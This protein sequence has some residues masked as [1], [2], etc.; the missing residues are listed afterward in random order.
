MAMLEPQH[1]DSYFAWNF[2][3]GILMQ[4][5]HFSSYVFEDLAA[6]MLKKDIGL[7][8]AFESKKRSDTTFAEDASA[9]LNWIYQ[10]SPYYEEGYKRYPIARVE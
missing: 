5:E 3:D 10:R 1:P 4:K 7:K 8:A 6:N 9:Q 2:M